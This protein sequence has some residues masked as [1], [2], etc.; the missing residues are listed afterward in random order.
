MNTQKQP[1]TRA[2]VLIVVTSDKFIEAFSSDQNIDLF[3][4]HAPETPISSKAE[5]VAE[6]LIERSL[7]TFWSRIFTQ[8]Y[9]VGLFSIRPKTVLDEIT[10]SIGLAFCRGLDE[11]SSSGKDAA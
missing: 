9:R 6:E 5:I 1:S 2:K 8:G 3:F 10:K 7:P 11:A 4:H